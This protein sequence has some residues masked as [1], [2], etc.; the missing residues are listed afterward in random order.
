MS[1]VTSLNRA[2]T[3]AHRTADKLPMTTLVQGGLI[4]TVSIR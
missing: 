3:Q 2:Y 4:N 1:F